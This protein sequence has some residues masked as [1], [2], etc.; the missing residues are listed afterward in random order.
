MSI[1]LTLIE[2]FEF[3]ETN[4]GCSSLLPAPQPLHPFA[5]L[6]CPPGTVRTTTVEFLPVNQFGP[7]MAQSQVDL[8]QVMQDW[9]VE[10]NKAYLSYWLAS[11]A[12]MEQVGHTRAAAIISASAGGFR[13]VNQAALATAMMRVPTYSLGEAM[14]L[15]SESWLRVFESASDPL[16]Q[17]DRALARRQ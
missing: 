5:P 8:D 13:V 14:A 11:E 2:I 16:H 1:I 15:F 12:L 9:V 10:V 6:V 17:L 7:S 4:F 3:G